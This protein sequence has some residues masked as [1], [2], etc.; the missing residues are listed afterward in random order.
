MPI[1]KVFFS[2]IAMNIVGPLSKSSAG[3]QYLLV[4]VDYATRFPEAVPMW[5]VTGP[6]VAE[7]IMRWIAWVGIPKE[8]T[9]DQGSNFIS[10]I[11]CGLC[12]VLHIKQL[13]TTVYHPQ[14]NGVV[15]RFN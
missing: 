14:T 1:I 10:N 11:I 15:E 2:C 5:S 4:I 7:E 13:C 9:T 12:K 8:I 3:H 6:W